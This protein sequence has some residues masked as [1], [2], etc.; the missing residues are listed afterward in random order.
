MGS[1]LGLQLKSL[2]KLKVVELHK[3]H[4][5]PV[6][7]SVAAE[8][9]DISPSLYLVEVRKTCGDATLYRQLCENLSH[10]LGVPRSQELLDTEFQ[11]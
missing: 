10:D 3:D 4:S 9:F 1:C 7:L 11:V 8:V 5:N 6:N 2:F